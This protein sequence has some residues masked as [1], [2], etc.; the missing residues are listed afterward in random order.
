MLK[1]LI[2]I[3]LFPIVVF[4]INIPYEYVHYDKNT[5]QLAVPDS[6]RIKLEFV[7]TGYD[8]T[9]TLT[10]GLSYIGNGYITITGR[11]D[12]FVTIYYT[13]FKTGDSTLA[14]S[15]P[16]EIRFD[17]SNYNSNYWHRTALHSDSGS[18]TQTGLYAWTYGS[19][20][21]TDKTGFS[22]SN[23]E[24]QAIADSVRNELERN[25]GFLWSLVHFWGTSDSAITVYYP[26]DGSSPKDSVVIYDAAGTRK[27]KVIY[28][29]SNNNTVLDSS[30]IY[31]LL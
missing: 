10:S 21:V 12:N 6:L 31:Y 27:L 19:R 4:A 23:A 30:L 18:V 25:E 20:T 17:T 28:K 3:L 24:R 13:F 9:F 1:K 15:S 29:H 11:T 2:L 22:L 14:Q 5:G 16:I 26:N 8:S 7:P